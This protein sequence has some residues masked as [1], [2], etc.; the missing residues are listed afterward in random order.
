MKKKL[1]ATLVAGAVLSTGIIGLTA[2][3][4][5]VSMPKG[6]QIADATAWAKAFEETSKLTNF[7]C[8]TSFT[9]D[10]KGE[11][12]L[13]NEKGEDQT[14]K[15][16]AKYS[17]YDLTAYD[18]DGD[19]AYTESNESMDM[20]ATSDGE[21]EK[22][23]YSSVE[24]YYYE[25]D[26][27]GEY[28]TS[29]WKASYGKKDIDSTDRKS[30][31]ENYWDAYSSY[32]YAS[33][34]LKKL[35]LDFYESDSTTASSKSITTL[36]DKFTYSGGVYTATLYSVVEIAEMGSDLIKVE[37]KVSFSGG[38][39]IGLS[40]KAKKVEGEL[41]LSE[42]NFKYTYS[43]EAVYALKDIN[44]TDVT[45]KAN[46]DINKAIQKAKDEKEDN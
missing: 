10:Q 39:V 40:Y 6:E 38:Y 34:P 29:Y 25:L 21:E 9:V 23:K 20:K 35:A 46:K 18:E 7:T 36:Y 45:K 27:K 4:N 19:K 2:C 31:T 37:V 13:K 12:T 15:Y 28:A 3:G 1:I 24:K 14:A 30:Y 44:K 33:N 22:L 8:E 42:G 43:T 17:T 11:G 41:S 26:E 16:T 32:D 5:S